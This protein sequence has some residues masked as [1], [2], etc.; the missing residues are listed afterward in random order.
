MGTDATKFVVPGGLSY[1]SAEVLAHQIDSEANGEALVSIG[2]PDFQARALFKQMN[3]HT[4]NFDELIMM[5]FSPELAS[6][7]TAAINAAGKQP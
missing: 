7:V 1:P 3:E 2:F 4:G 5:G 6:A